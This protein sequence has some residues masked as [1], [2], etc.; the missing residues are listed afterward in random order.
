MAGT[1]NLEAARA[2]LARAR[3]HVDALERE[4]TVGVKEEAAYAVRFSEV[5]PQTGWCSVD[6]VPNQIEKPRLS[7][8][9]GDVIHNLRCALD[10]VVTALADA[11]PTK[12][13]S[14]HQ[15]PI[16]LTP[17]GYTSQ[18]GSA[19]EAK[20]KGP[21]REI[22]VGLPL[23]E[24]WQPFHTQ[25]DPRTDPLWGIYRF[26]N[27]DKH[28]QPLTFAPRPVGAFEIGFNGIPVEEKPGPDIAD[29][30]PDQEIHLKRIR[31]DPPQAYSFHVKGEISLDV[32]F[33]TPAFGGDADLAIALRDL[34]DVVGHVAKM[35]DLFGEL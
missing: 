21:L 3:E 29:W 25:P 14:K 34:S 30:T 17:A 24:K 27:A 11:T 6:L 15:F 18:V 32:G 4:T 22:T 13:S 12:L 23:V 35:L 7:V 1:L 20:S 8:I 9:L 10:Y 5:D 16:Y 33:R 19:S 31:F 26:S 2:K 28:R